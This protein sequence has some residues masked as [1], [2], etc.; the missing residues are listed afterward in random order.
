M[1]GEPYLMLRPQPISSHQYFFILLSAG[2]LLLSSKNIGEFLCVI[3]IE[4]EIKYSFLDL[5]MNGF[6]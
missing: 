5:F 6:F 3:F 4:N 1:T 2:D